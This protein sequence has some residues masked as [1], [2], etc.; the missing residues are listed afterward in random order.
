MTT[1]SQDE[2]TRLAHQFWVQRGSPAG[3]PDTDW[4]RAK[5][6]LEGRLP[7]LTRKV[8]TIFGQA[9]ALVKPRHLRI[10]FFRARS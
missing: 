6:L 5:R 10:S 1:A 8:G 4:R 7:K 2:I 9:V 3:S